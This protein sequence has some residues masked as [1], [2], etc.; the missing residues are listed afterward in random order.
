VLIH[1]AQYTDPE[2]ERRVGWGHSTLAQAM[3]FADLAGVRRLVTFHHDPGHD[4][5]MLDGMLRGARTMDG[6]EMIGGREGLELDTA[7]AQQPEA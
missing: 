1:D 2:Y 4:D 6:V 3:S 7:V 5:A